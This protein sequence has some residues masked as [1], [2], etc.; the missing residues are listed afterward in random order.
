MELTAKECGIQL[1]VRGVGNYLKR[2]K[3]KPQK[4]VK[5]KVTVKKKSR[6]DQSADG[7]AF[8]DLA[9]SRLMGER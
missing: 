9:M 7:S 4:T 3:F 5:A 8:N 1:T 6:Q 2:W